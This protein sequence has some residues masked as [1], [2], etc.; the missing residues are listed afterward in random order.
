MADGKVEEQQSA[1][2]KRYGSRAD[3]AQDMLPSLADALIPAAL[4]ASWF[5]LGHYPGTMPLCGSGQTATT[6]LEDDRSVERIV[7]RIQE[8][9]EEICQLEVVRSEAGIPSEK[10]MADCEKEMT[11]LLVRVGGDPARLKKRPGY[12]D[13]VKLVGAIQPTC[14][15]TA[16]VIWKAC[17]SIAHGEVGVMAYLKA[18]TVGSS[19]PPGMSHHW[20]CLGH[21]GHT[22]RA[23]PGALGAADRGVA[24]QSAARERASPPSLRQRVGV[25][26]GSPGGRTDTG[27]S[28]PLV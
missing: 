19:I 4:R 22:A 5:M 12:G 1:D 20:P 10:T 27:G 9:W 7:R 18:T 16:F 25:A 23:G 3:P 15:T 28:L 11:D 21:R 26:A 14:S 17:S 13:I 2:A 6:L 24:H 8:D